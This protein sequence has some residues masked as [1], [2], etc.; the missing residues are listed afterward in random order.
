ME[1]RKNKRPKKEYKVEIVYAEDDANYSL[2]LLADLVLDE[3]RRQRAEKEATV[4]IE[5]SDNDPISAQKK[6]DQQKNLSQ[7]SNNLNGAP[8]SN[9]DLPFPIGAVVKLKS[10]G[11][12][13][14]VENF[15][16]YGIGDK[17]IR[18]LCVY[19]E[20]NKRIEQDFALEAL[21]EI[22]KSN[23]KEIKR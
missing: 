4:R 23:K 14:T 15:G 3:I 16:E 9:R 8:M 6:S 2:G 21:E 11:P 7:S 17:S 5:E 22:Q 12:V 20:N 1:S 18:A 13:M 10:G 19:F